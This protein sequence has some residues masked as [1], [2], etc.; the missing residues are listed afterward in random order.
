MKISTKARYGI[1]AL[2]DL[3]IHSSTDH[4]ALK[5]IAERQN[6]SER[7]LEQVFAQLRKSGL[8]K[9]VKGPQGGYLLAIAPDKTSLYEIITALEGCDTFSESDV[10][11]VL[12]AADQVV[13]SM[14][15]QPLDLKIAAHLKSVTLN[16]LIEAYQDA[17]HTQHMMFFI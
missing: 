14:L 3:A 13:D 16:V 7:Y 10:N 1:K 11:A 8:V 4:V 17:T 9:S 2:I 12:D 6:I 15:W 5:A